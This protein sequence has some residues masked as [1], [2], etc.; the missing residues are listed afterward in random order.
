MGC[1][2]DGCVNTFDVI[3][4]TRP[5]HMQLESGT[6]YAIDLP[7]ECA[8]PGLRRAHLRAARPHALSWPS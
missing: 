7:V 3:S 8:E 2:A 4:P 6:V 1:C 5:G